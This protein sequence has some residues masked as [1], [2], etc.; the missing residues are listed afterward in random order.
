MNHPISN[1][2]GV[3]EGAVSGGVFPAAQAVVLHRGV[4]VFGGVAGAA[5]GDTRFDLASVTKVL[6]TT[7]LFLRLWTE[8]KAGQVSV[9]ALVMLALV[10]LF[11][12]AE[13]RLVRTHLGRS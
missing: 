12:F 1:L 7:S 5:T 4:Q 9:I 2:Q 10:F 8:G 11:R 13:G 6:C 3:L